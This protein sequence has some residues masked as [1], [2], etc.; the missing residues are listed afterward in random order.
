MKIEFSKSAEEVLPKLSEGEADE[1]LGAVA[2]RLSGPAHELLA[3]ESIE[4]P[5]LR[6]RMRAYHRS[7]VIEAI[8]RRNR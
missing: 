4:T 6:I 7:V 5:S 2:N 8:E 1:L 3:V